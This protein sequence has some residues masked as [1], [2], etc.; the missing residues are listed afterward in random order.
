M[1]YS[2]L[3]G[4]LSAGIISM[5]V[6]NAAVIDTAKANAEDLKKFS[7]KPQ[8]MKVDGKDVFATRPKGTWQRFVLKKK[9][10]VDPAK[11][12]VISVKLKQTGEKPVK[13]WIGFV[14]TTEKGRFIAP[15][16][17]CNSNASM[18]TLAES[19]VKGTKTI[20]VKDASKWKKGRHY[21]IAF[22]AKK[23][24]SDLPNFGLSSMISKIE[25]NTIT[26]TS[27]LK[28][29]YP[30]DTQVRQHR[31]GGTY[32]YTKSGDVPKEWKVWKGRSVKK[33]NF[34]K[35]TYIQPVVL[36]RIPKDGSVIFDEIVVEEL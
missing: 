20:K 7:W 36:F 22:N 27:P 10:K 6:A 23:D 15:A 2:K 16:N 19:A 21:Y 13:V 8:L 4:I 35:G 31:S 18:T 28:K 29:A 12:Y 24:M 17:V 14:P 26:L 1:H 30:A 5:T 34:R 11:K 25:Q 32:V 3:A 9:I 33:G